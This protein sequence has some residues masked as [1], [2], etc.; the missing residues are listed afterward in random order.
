MLLLGDCNAKSKSWFII[1]QSSSQ[2]V[3]LESLTLLYGMKQLISESTHGLE[4]SSSCI[5][6]ISM[7]QPKLVMDPGVHPSLHLKCY[8]KIKLYA[9]NLI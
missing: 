2:E 8:M 7:N 9:P 1:D 3:K 4:N 6:F 5:D